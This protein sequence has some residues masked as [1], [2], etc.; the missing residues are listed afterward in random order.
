[1]PTIGSASPSVASQERTAGQSPESRKSPCPARNDWAATPPEVNFLIST[2]SPMS[3]QIPFST[4][5]TGAKKWGVEPV[6]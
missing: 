4:A 6:R 1:M 2:L 3:L 5:V